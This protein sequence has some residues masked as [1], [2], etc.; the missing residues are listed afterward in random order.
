MV[1]VMLKKKSRPMMEPKM[2][3]VAEFVTLGSRNVNANLKISKPTAAMM[4]PRTR[5]DLVPF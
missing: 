2:W 4:E 5:A 1:A 3:P